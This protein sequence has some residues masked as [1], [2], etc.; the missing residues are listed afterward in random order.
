MQTA[1]GRLQQIDKSREI[2]KCDPNGFIKGVNYDQFTRLLQGHIENEV[3]MSYSSTCTR[4]CDDYTFIK[5]TTSV[6]CHEQGSEYCQK[7]PKCNGNV[8]SCKFVESKATICISVGTYLYLKLI[9]PDLHCSE[10]PSEAIRVCDLR[11]WI[12][13]R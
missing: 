5:R 12:N 6:T 8:I 2:V 9:S 13:I 4:T 7:V 3:D 1:S 10:K 11:K